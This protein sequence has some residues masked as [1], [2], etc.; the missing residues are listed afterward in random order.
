MTSLCRSLLSALMHLPHFNHTTDDARRH[1]LHDTVRLLE[2]LG[3]LDD[4]EV[5]LEKLDHLFDET[6]FGGDDPQLPLL[7]RLRRVIRQQQTLQCICEQ[8]L[9][10]LFQFVSLSAATALAQAQTGWLVIYY[11]HVQYCDAIAKLLQPSY[12]VM[13]RACGAGVDVINHNLRP[14]H[15]PTLA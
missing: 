5:T 7:P 2:K 6:V 11:G 3:T 10:V 15:T 9:S 13:R 12:R 8:L 4:E 1:I 14:D